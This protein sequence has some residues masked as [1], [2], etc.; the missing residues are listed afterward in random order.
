MKL[1]R[2]FFQHSRRD[3][4]LSLGAGA[5][6]GICN[7]ALLGVINGVIK[8]NGS[9][10]RVLLWTFVGLC[11]LL[12]LSRF[13][14]EVLLSKLGQGALYT[15]RMQLCRQILA[16]PLRHLEQISGP[17]LLTVLTDDIPSI[18]NAIINLPLLCVNFA[19][20][21][22]CL[23]YMA[24][25]SSML[26]GI[27]M[28]FMV[29]GIISYQLPILKVSSVFLLA[30]KESDKLQEHFRALTQG[31]K[32]LKIHAERREAFVRDG[33]ES[34]SGALMR[35]NVSGLRIYGGAASWGQTLVFV[36]I[37]LILFV[38]PLFRP[39]STAMLTAYAITLLYLMTPLQV[40]M[41]ALP[42]I[43]R[44][45]VALKNV[46]DMGFTLTSE[47]VEEGLV[48]SGPPADWKELELRGVTHSYRREGEAESFTLGPVN[49]KFHPGELVFIV[50]GNGGGKTTL[51][52]L[53]IGLY[54]PEGGEI[55]MNNQTIDG[56]NREL[57]RQYFSVVFSDFY[58]FDQLM[59]MVTPD[60]DEQARRYLEDL[61]LTHKVQIEQGKFSTTEL[62]QGQRK[63]LA[64]LTAYL[65]DRPIYLFDEW[66][67]DQDPYFKNV[68]YTQL[69]PALR[70]R[71][72]TVLV[73]SH[74]D[75]YYYL[76]DRIIKLD[77]GKIVSDKANEPQ[78][79]AVQPAQAVLA[80]AAS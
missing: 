59:G 60:L 33:L 22:G 57:Y 51:A 15:L 44:A 9:A 38:L 41:N 18:T 54:A 47:G 6:S 39:L 74:D 16:A 4:L 5:F 65:E 14:A 28:G 61:K 11:V 19:L 13:T 70:A 63:R 26:F 53:I 66:A 3:V 49:L 67:A 56:S 64:L 37:G 10:L 31:A 7:A 40:I 12:P 43:S 48:K 75:R 17:R 52:K 21:V 71:N 76:A 79:Q 73:I 1:I 35:H 29:L 55:H 32:E 77:D 42:V 23:V 20:V 2:F 46:H 27:V 30:R 50:G 78:E 68:F 69:L 45:N 25:L 58:L 24:M 62:S 80:T 8:N 36:V 34:T 72:K